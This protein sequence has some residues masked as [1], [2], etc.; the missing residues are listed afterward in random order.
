MDNEVADALRRFFEKDLHGAAAVYLFGSAAHGVLRHDSDIDVGVL[1]SQPPPSTLEGQPF[2]L[3]DE[4]E[5][6]LG[7]PVDVVV[8]N[9][10]PAD[11][12]ARVLRLGRL[13]LERDRSARIRFEVLTR[14]EAFDLEPVLR[15]YRDPSGKAR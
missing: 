4:L 1:L 12:R 8:L 14:N 9:T 5:R 10:A 11:L 2:D 6:A 13:V 7:R 15:R 3:E